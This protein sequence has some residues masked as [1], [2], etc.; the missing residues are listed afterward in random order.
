VAYGG[1]RTAPTFD[2]EKEVGPGSPVVLTLKARLR[3]ADFHSLSRL[4]ERKIREQ[5]TDMFGASS[6]DAKRDIAGITLNRW[7]HAY[8]SPQPGILLWQRREARLP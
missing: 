7:G 2:T 6:F 8:A 3:R 5:L 4:Y 1:I